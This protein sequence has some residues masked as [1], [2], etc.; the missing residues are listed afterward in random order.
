MPTDEQERQEKFLAT[1][2]AL[3]LSAER[4]VSIRIRPDFLDAMR[5]VRRLVQRMAPDGDFRQYAGSA[6]RQAPDLGTRYLGD[7]GGVAP[8]S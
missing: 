8:L 4:A 2:L 5:R 6:R 3:A 7:G 1:L